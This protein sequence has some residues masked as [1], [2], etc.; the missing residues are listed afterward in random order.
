MLP[1]P[2]LV[3][4]LILV[5][6]A[7][8]IAVLIL[9][10]V[11]KLIAILVTQAVLIARGAQLF[12]RD[13]LLTGARLHFGAVP[14]AQVHALL[15]R[16]HGAHLL[17][18]LVAFLLGHQLS[19]VDRLILVNTVAVTVLVSITVAILLASTVLIHRAVHGPHPVLSAVLVELRFPRGGPP[20]LGGRPSGRTGCRCG[21]EARE[22]TAQQGD[23]K[24][25]AQLQ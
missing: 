19:A 7:K 2:V 11:A 1:E 9:V 15:L 25:R 3:A 13:S 24:Q 23:T 17:P 21:G 4:V 5:G 18:I 20:I 16:A 14:G 10:G 22:R 12:H 8:L 6:V